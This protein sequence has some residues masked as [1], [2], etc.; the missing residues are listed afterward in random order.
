MRK[1]S[2]R[3]EWFFR[4]GTFGQLAIAIAVCACHTDEATRTSGIE[5]ADLCAAVTNDSLPDGY[6]SITSFGAV[7]DGVTD[8]YAA[9]RASAAWLA[10]HPGGGIV[11]PPGRYKVNRIHDPIFHSGVDDGVY[12][13]NIAY[14]GLD[15]VRIQGCDA[16][17]VRK[18]DFHQP[19]DVPPD[20]NTSSQ[21]PLDVFEFY[22]SSYFVLDGF[23][24]LGEVELTTRDAIAQTGGYG[25]VVAGSDHY[26]LSNLDI[27]GFQM[28]GLIV[29]TS[30]MRGTAPPYEIM[31]DTDFVV[32]NVYSHHNGRQALTINQARRGTFTNV[33]L[34]HTRDVGAYGGF[35]PGAGVDIEPDFFPGIAPEFDITQKTGDLVFDNVRIHDNPGIAFGAAAGW[36]IENVAIRNS[37]IIGV[38]HPISGP[39]ILFGIANAVIEN[40]YLDM[41]DSYLAADGWGPE[42]Y[43]KQNP[44]LEN[45]YL[46]VSFTM[47]NCYLTSSGPGLMFEAGALESEPG[48]TFTAATVEDNVFVGT[49]PSD[50]A[51]TFPALGSPYA[52][53]QRNFVQYPATWSNEGTWPDAPRI[54]ANIDAAI[55]ADNTFTSAFPTPGITYLTYGA[56]TAVSGD[57]FPTPDALSV[58]P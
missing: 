48:T 21:T 55:S 14:R 11:Y 33:E 46:T 44:A 2:N 35:A 45:D 13:D 19:A 26:Q 43:A 7:G 20:Y 29:G 52:V 1:T 47:R 28:D 15:H 58:L 53:F 40:S 31:F 57:V 39:P 23:T 8:D 25:V 36:A 18:G 10:E 32:E 34:A 12:G 38:D 50:Y 56:A 27:S 37:T 24:L 30:Y 42:A 54:V 49:Q 41:R 17:V 5:A 6:V 9:L 4:L 22:D 3:I 16:T 51:G